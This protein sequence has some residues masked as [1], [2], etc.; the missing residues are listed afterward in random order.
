MCVCVCVCLFVCLC[1]RVHALSGSLIT[2]VFKVDVGYER[3]L[4]PEIFFHPE[5]SNPD[6]VTPISEVVDTVIQNCPIDC[7]R[8]LY[9]VRHG[10][11]LTAS[12]NLCKVIGVNC[13]IL[14]MGGRGDRNTSLLH[15]VPNAWCPSNAWCP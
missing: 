4:G 8:P 13:S 6:F 9:K 10:D 11:H 5:F 3:F 14:S 15:D 2:Q 7:R 12:L 1:V